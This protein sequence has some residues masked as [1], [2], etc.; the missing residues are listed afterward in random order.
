MG[1]SW[2]IFVLVCLLSF[3]RFLAALPARIRRLI[4]IAGTVY[5]G[6]ALGV[7][8]L[9]GYY[10]QMYSNDNMMYSILTTIEESMEML[11]II[12]FIYALLSY[13]GSYMKGLNLK[14]NF[15]DEKKQRQNK[16]IR[17]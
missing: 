1:N 14:V 13:I 10:A 8:M 9:D 3:V 12:I 6:S 17:N 4:L 5:V 11:G 15:I 16:L 2:G 7:E